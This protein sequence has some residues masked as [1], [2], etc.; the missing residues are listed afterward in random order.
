LNSPEPDPTLRN[1]VKAYAIFG[2]DIL[3]N[4]GLSTTEACRL[5]ARE[6]ERAEI[7]LGNR[8]TTQPWKLVKGWR[9]RMTKL[10]VTDQ[11]RNLLEEMRRE[12]PAK[13]RSPEAASAFVTAILQ[14]RLGKL[15]KGAL[16]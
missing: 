16:E 15:P 7:S 11:A 3:S 5:V 1:I 9:D 6:L 13:A 12:L 2:I 10:P 14:E 8:T 4:S